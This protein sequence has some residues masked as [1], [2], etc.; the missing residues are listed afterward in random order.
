MG[1][2]DHRHGVSSALMAVDHD[3]YALIRTNRN[4]KH[5]TYREYP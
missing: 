2:D 3:L 1:C 4:I 5:D